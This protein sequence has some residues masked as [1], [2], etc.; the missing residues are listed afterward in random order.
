MK[1]YI[2][3]LISSLDDKVFYVGKG[4]GKR[5]YSHV[6]IAKSNGVNRKSNPHLYN[7]ISKIL[8]EGGNILYDVVFKSDDEKEIYEK[9]KEFINNIGIENL[10]NLREGGIGGLIG[11]WSE[12]RKNKLSLSKMGKPRSDETKEKIRNTLKGVPTGRSYW[13]GKSLSEETK[14]KM[15][16]S[17]KG[18]NKGPISEKRRLAIIEGIRKKKEEKENSILLD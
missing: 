5:M 4:S 10:T 6:R 14:E 15:R 12:D 7:K 18:K 17:G 3:C 11:E 16:K 1:F 2:Y 13:K 9:E 8:S